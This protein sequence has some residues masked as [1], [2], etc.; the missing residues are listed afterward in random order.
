VIFHQNNYVCY[1]FINYLR[2]FFYNITIF[3]F[4]GYIAFSFLWFLNKYLFSISIFYAVK[5]FMVYINN[6]KISLM[7]RS[8]RCY[9]IYKIFVLIIQY[10]TVIIIIFSILTNYSYKTIKLLFAFKYI[11]R[12][13]V[14]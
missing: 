11:L 14:W 6:L 7:C 2:K 5:S 4:F 3:H 8:T 10:Y 9:F 1:Y 13:G 12:R